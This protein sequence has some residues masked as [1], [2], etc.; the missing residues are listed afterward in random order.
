MG[1]SSD[2]VQW[3]RGRGEV[4]ERSPIS[5]GLQWH[6]VSI[7]PIVGDLCRSRF[8]NTDRKLYIYIIVYIILRYFGAGQDRDIPT[9]PENGNIDLTIPRPNPDWNRDIFLPSLEIFKYF[10]IFNT[11][12][13]SSN[14][15]K[16]Q[17][18]LL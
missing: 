17:K 14:F 5:E 11:Y 3:I 9:D 7:V 2:D 4:A 18:I 8:L 13:F 16:T 15:L 6:E 12:A 1:H 10:S